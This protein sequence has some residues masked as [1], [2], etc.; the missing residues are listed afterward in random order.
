MPK[1]L[2][3]PDI[4]S[5]S[6]D[7]T[8][9]STYYS[10]LHEDLERK[11]K[12]IKRREANSS[13]APD[14][15]APN[16]TTPPPSAFTH[17]QHQCQLFRL[18]YELRNLIY[19]YALQKP[20]VPRL[21]ELSHDN[22]PDAEPAFL[23]CCRRARAEALPVFYSTNDWVVKVRRVNTSLDPVTQL[24]LHDEIVPGWVRRLADYKM[25]HVRRVVVVG[26]RGSYFGGTG[27]WTEGPTAAF[28]MRMGVLD[29]RG[30]VDEVH[31]EGEESWVGEE[32]ALK[33]VYDCGVRL[34]DLCKAQLRH[35][36]LLEGRDWCWDSG[37]LRDFAGFL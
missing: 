5:S 12:R 8:E 22:R 24:R 34:V 13:L 18:P 7:D 30:I 1:R 31:V 27:D 6:G 23:K 11:K 10:T 16:A 29:G 15:P 21:L 28:R 33:E 19:T 9:S 26:S 36:N 37:K 35:H 4:S 17:P 25:R 2:Q 3:S 14:N 20:P 32:K